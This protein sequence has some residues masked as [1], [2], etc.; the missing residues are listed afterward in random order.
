MRLPITPPKAQLHSSQT[1]PLKAPYF[2][3]GPNQHLLKA[4]P[5]AIPFE[6]A[7]DTSKA[8]SKAI[9][10]RTVPKPLTVVPN[11]K[12]CGAAP[13]F[14]KAVPKS[15]CFGTAPNFQTVVTDA[16]FWGALPNFKTNLKGVPF[17]K[18]PNRLKVF[19]HHL[20]VE[21]PN[22]Y[23]LFVNA[24][25]FGVVQDF[26]E[27]VPNANSCAAALKFAKAVTIAMP[28]GTTPILIKRQRP[29]L[30]PS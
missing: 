2:C 10:C 5:K 14:V 25:D 24:T 15:I 6:T 22:T 17:G 30:T 16:F 19:Q 12:S 28:F 9:P 8:V 3:F 29:L 11:Q 21:Q 13:S 26:P 4:N 27:G 20:F 18:A 1:P 7:R 23:F